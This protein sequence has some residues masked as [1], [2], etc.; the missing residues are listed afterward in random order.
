MTRIFPILIAFATS[1]QVKAD[2]MITFT[3]QNETYIIPSA[4]YHK[5]VEFGTKLANDTIAA[6]NN[7]TSLVTSED[8]QK[9]TEKAAQTLFDYAQKDLRY[10]DNDARGFVVITLVTAQQLL[11]QEGFKRAFGQH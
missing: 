2:E 9:N 8:L 5:A 7:S 10:N 4:V 6:Q 1:A 3:Y 11:V